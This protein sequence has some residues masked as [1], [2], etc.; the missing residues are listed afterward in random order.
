MTGKAYVSLSSSLDAYNIKK[1]F[2]KKGII[3]NFFGIFPYQ[4]SYYNLDVEGE[5]FKLG[6]EEASEPIDI[7]WE[8]LNYSDRN[9]FFRRAIS[10]LLSILVVILLF[11]LLFH[12]KSERIIQA[13]V[14]NSKLPN[15]NKESMISMQKSLTLMSSL[16]ISIMNPIINFIITN[17]SERLEKHHD[18][19]SLS[20][21][22]TGKLWKVNIIF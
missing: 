14:E 13:A 15:D 16:I 21:A 10:S 8:N 3:Y 20:L 2:K 12:L 22:L 1:K 18:K 11:S 4:E 7:I 9:R 17:L 19:T 6:V 5:V